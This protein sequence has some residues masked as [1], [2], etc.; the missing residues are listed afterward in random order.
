MIMPKKENKDEE[1][2]YYD[3][4]KLGTF[5]VWCLVHVLKKPTGSANQYV[6]LMYT[7]LLSVNIL[8]TTN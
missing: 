5:K 7:L 2:K 6:Q 3:D 4:L 1:E 8:A